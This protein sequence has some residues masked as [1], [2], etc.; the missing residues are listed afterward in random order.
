MSPFPDYPLG[1]DVHYWCSSSDMG[2]AHIMREAVGGAIAWRGACAAV[3]Y[4]PPTREAAKGKPRCG[5]C[6]DWHDEH[7]KILV[8]DYDREK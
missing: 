2:M 7:P 1:T 8:P 4:Y 5:M 6:A 3:P